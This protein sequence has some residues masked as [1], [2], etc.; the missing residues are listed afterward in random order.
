M[1]QLFGKE[2]LSKILKWSST[3]VVE[4]PAAAENSKLK[5]LYKSSRAR[6]D[7]YTLR[8]AWGDSIFPEERSSITGYRQDV[9]HKTFAVHIVNNSGLNDPLIFYK[10]F[11]ALLCRFF[12]L[13]LIIVHYWANNSIFNFGEGKTFTSN[14]DAHVF[15]L[16][17]LNKCQ[18]IYISVKLVFKI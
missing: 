7:C 9:E 8:P 5:M 17:L 16:D 18:W 6:F 2:K 15:L 1:K 13:Q 3:T 4:M 10:I 12:Q 11:S 14:V